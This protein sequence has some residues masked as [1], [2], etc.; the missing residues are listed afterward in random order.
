MNLRVGRE[1]E[2]H[3][4]ASFGDGKRISLL[5]AASYRAFFGNKGDSFSSV[6]F[7]HLRS[8]SFPLIN[9]G[10]LLLRGWRE[11]TPRGFS[12]K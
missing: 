7:L 12:I 2:S 1:R 11:P 10:M 4:W 5:T 8:S 6:R 9:R 3:R